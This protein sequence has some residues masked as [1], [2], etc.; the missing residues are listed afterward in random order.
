MKKT[1]LS[2]VGRFIEILPQ[3]PSVSQESPF[4]HQQLA[5]VDSQDIQS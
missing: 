5:Q 3:L 4:D 1:E 2:D